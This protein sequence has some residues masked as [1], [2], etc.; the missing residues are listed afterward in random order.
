MSVFTKRGPYNGARLEFPSSPSALCS[1]AQGLNQFASVWTCE[2]AAQ[3][4]FAATVPGLFGSPTSSGRFRPFPFQLKVTP[5]AL[6]LSTTKS[7]KPEM[8]LSIRSI[9][10]FPRIVLTG[11]IGRASCRERG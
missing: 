1:K 6:L 9:S 3:V 4:G 10:Q 7:G 8:A 11:Q 2:G 5:E